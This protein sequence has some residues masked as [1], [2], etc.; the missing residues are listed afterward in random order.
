MVARICF[1][2][3]ADHLTARASPPVSP[4][5]MEMLFIADEL[6]NIWILFECSEKRTSGSLVRTQ[7]ILR[8]QETHIRLVRH[9]GSLHVHS[10][11]L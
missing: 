9:W 11:E 3:E 7:L 1:A 5:I 10:S 2:N 4:P 8:W 6:G